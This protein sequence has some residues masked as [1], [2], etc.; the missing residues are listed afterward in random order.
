MML[1]LLKS[2]NLLFL[3]IVLLLLG[4]TSLYAQNQGNPSNFSIRGDVYSGTPIL[5]SPLSDDWFKGPTGNGMIDESS[6]AS[7]LD[8]TVTRKN[9]PFTARSP[10]NQ[11]KELNG[12]LLYDAIYGRDYVDFNNEGLGKDQTAFTGSSGKNGDNPQTSWRTSKNESVVKKSDL[13]D[14]YAHLRRSG[15]TVGT[16]M[17]LTMGVSTLSN[18]GSHF[19]DFELY[20][21]P[22][23]QQ[24]NGFVNS[25]LNSTEGHTPW[26]LD[27][28]GKITS[29][30]DLI[31]GFAFNGPTVSGVELRIWTE[32]STFESGASPQG[33]SWGP[34]FDGSGNGSIYG[35]AQIIIPEGGVFDSGNTLSVTG[36]PWKTLYD[37]GGNVTSTYEPGFFAEVAVNL[38]SLGIDPS[39]SSGNPCDAPFKKIF[40]KSRSSESFTSN[41]KDFA[42]PYNF[43]GA[44]VV[45][46]QIKKDAPG[47]LQCG[48]GSLGLSPLNPQTGSYYVWSTADGEFSN[49]TKTFTGKDA[50]AVKPGTYRL[51]AAPLE[52]CTESFDEIRIYAQPCTQPDFGEIVEN[53]GLNGS[54]TLDVSL[55]DSDLDGDLDP[56]SV[57]INFTYK[58]TP[59][60]KVQHGTLTVAGSGLVTY[61]PYP[62]YYGLDTV[63]YVI[64]DGTPSGSP[65]FGP[66]NNKALIT[67]NVLRDSDADN[68]PDR[69]DLDDDND[70]IPDTLE[71]G[72]TSSTPEDCSGSPN[73]KFNSAY[74][75]VSGDG[76]NGT[77]LK[78]EIFKFTDILPGINSFVTIVDVVNASVRSF[79]V[80]DYPNSFQPETNYPALTTGQRAYVEYKFEFKK[81][82]GTPV[83]IPEFYVNFNDV[84]GQPT[85]RELN[86]TEL[87]ES[88]TLND[89]TEITITK[90]GNW[91]IGTSGNSSINGTSDAYPEINYSTK[92]I[93]KSSYSIRVGLEAT[94]STPAAYRQ[95]HVQFSC[96]NN[97]TNPVIADLQYDF[98]GDG[99]PNYLDLDSDNDG[100]PDVVEAGLLD[101]N[102]DGL[103]DVDGRGY[104]ANGLAD[105]VETASDSGVINYI[106]INSDAATD[107]STNMYDFIDV[108]SDNDG[109][110]DTAET[111][112]NNPSYNDGDN[113]GQVDGFV[114][115]N[116]NGW[117]DPL[118][119][120]ATFPTPL[121]SDADS[122]PN[123]RDLDSDGDGLPDT[124]EGNFDLADS[125]NDGIVGTGIPADDDKDG[126]AN[127]NDPDFP[128]NILGGSGFNKD[129]DNDGVL[130]YIDIDYDNDGIIDNTEAQ[131]T[132]A[133]IAPTGND[134]DGDG[135]DDAYDI[136]N[137]GF[138][139]GYINT[140]GGWAPDYADV[141]SDGDAEYDLVENHLDNSI[142]V[143]KDNIINSTGNNGS[144]GMVDPN[145]PD[146]DGDGLADIFEIKP[147]D[148]GPFL[149]GD[150]ANAT[151]G[152]Q[153]PLTQ[154]DLEN[155]G[156]DRDW[157]EQVVNDND[158]DG[159]SDLN[160]EDDD[161]DGI[162]DIVEGGGD[163][164]GD[165]VVFYLDAD[166]NDSSN[167][168]SLDPPNSLND[169]DGDGLQNSFDLDSDGDGI[170][171]HIE[172]GGTF[173][174][175]G[176]GTPG[177]GL[178]T[179][180]D[181]NSVGVPLQVTAVGGFNGDGTDGLN[182]ID[183]D[184]DGL[185]D[186]LDLD[187]DNDGIG[188]VIEAGGIDPDGNGVYGAGS[189]NDID[190]DGLADDL[191]ILYNNDNP[192]TGGNELGNFMGGTPLTILIGV[193]H[194]VKDTDGD[195]YPDNLDLDSDDDTIPDIVEA[196]TTLGYIAYNSADINT[197]GLKDVYDVHQGGTG[198]IPVDTDGDGTP[199]YL[200]L[201]SD[202]EGA[203][204]IVEANSAAVPNTGGRTDG[205]VGINGLDNAF[206]GPAG[207][208]YA[209]PNGKHDNTQFDNFPDNDA[210]VLTGGDVDY[211][212]SSFSDFDEDGIADA[213][214]LDD[215]NDG[216][217]D[218]VE[219]SEGYPPG[220]SRDPADDDDTDGIPNYKDPDF[221]T[222]GALN[223]FGICPEFDIDGDGIPNH[224]DLD[225]DGDG[226]SDAIEATATTDPTTEYQF[227][228]SPVG[229]D[230][231]PDT[232]QGADK[233]G[234]AINYA[235][236]QTFNPTYDFL[237]VD[238]F[239]ACKADLSLNKTVN[240]PSAAIGDQIIFTLTLTNSGPFSVSK[241]KV[242]DKL[243][244][245]LID[246]SYTSSYGSYDLFTGIWDLTT[247]TIQP[248]S[249][250]NVETLQIT[251]TIGPD[252]QPI[253]N[254]AE[255]FSSER[256]DPDSIPNNG[257]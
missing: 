156:N 196:Q 140:D 118:D 23:E 92:Q 216:I 101:A 105:I 138:A 162:L 224:F 22:F 141:N 107:I 1:K 190:A 106:P 31:V 195:G 205:V 219:S 202:N 257:L 134:T 103:V 50:T 240:N 119:A 61:T 100:I 215:D 193:V 91:L 63:E 248:I 60:L 102:N 88:Y 149:P 158:N 161:N 210:D 142:D 27:N 62:G 241:V 57:K 255:V 30:G 242:R 201:D 15:V 126:L 24:G 227:P 170:P 209:D 98:D 188:D 251:A 182:P 74:T 109:I 56:A 67:F 121:N 99:I 231:I 97:Y 229:T 179:T 44:S 159:Y 36:P 80:N 221:C 25:G 150:A 77:F 40:I 197:N 32:R 236:A 211:R 94:A 192:S 96:T 7:F 143:R 55:N 65:H 238:V 145:E 9:L 175:D 249:P 194:Q 183:T 82:D 49:G 180:S 68:V 220:A 206:D 10:Y 53:N 75:E 48:S 47:Y 208:T 234:G 228:A 232:V 29:S 6:K 168:N 131:S 139:I 127:T 212:D 239:V 111:F 203:P 217:P 163:N 34:A 166:D 84:D 4:S 114:D 130:N 213:L 235:V 46:T 124:V 167:T 20:A 33:F 184:L 152:G 133:Y 3:L 157:R 144:D 246:I 104:G 199:D 37:G 204:D 254:N 165:G 187:S 116:K 253:I 54:I 39:L 117:H 72:Q 95:H 169:I 42:G 73:M 69:D 115:V 89:P 171:D 189:I 93:N 176:N 18:D 243:P 28:T 154:P 237:D 178:L 26:V 19:V 200:D 172:A 137:G 41:L 112:S 230:G 110:T 148:G 123:Y 128:G 252:C 90:E 86:W 35:Y 125:D 14:V 17:W 78:G 83:I 214:D 87:P 5:T 52:G 16:N 173:D 185:Y 2:Y 108:D 155:P 247:H 218:T 191:D 76:L 226:C 79:D 250:D 129:R 85:L 13:V 147:V 120:E 64:Y 12:F 66:L 135:L 181:V 21:E 122:L 81:T 160:D 177:T 153:T 71:Q 59:L 38:S 146:T 132:F 70:G 8:I 207:D 233:N 225:S 222:G 151:N 244:D 186:Y 45:D 113:N 43:L 58:G 256:A 51:S 223:A 245:G 174:G 136:N 11:Y 198:I 164:D